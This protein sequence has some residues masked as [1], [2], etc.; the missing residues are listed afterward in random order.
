MVD[1]AVSSQD[2]P[3][4]NIVLTGFMGSGKTAVGRALAASLDREFVDTD[5]AIEAVRGPIPSIFRY[6]GEE[7]F[8]AH[9][10]EL[11]VE[12]AARRNLVVSTGG[13]MLIDEEVAD[14][15]ASTGRIFCLAASPATVLA[16]VREQ[17]LADRPLL[18]V[19][20]PEGRITELLAERS[21]RY[22]TFERVPTDGRRVD[23]IVADLIER[24]VAPA[25]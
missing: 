4:G 16:R 10:A 13:G 6:Q 2:V 11:A 5:T 25:D 7:A 23:E 1:P 21:A 12:L 9:E 15:L 8:R 19:A 24:L 18:D 17:G 14:R 20:D 22:A 3:P